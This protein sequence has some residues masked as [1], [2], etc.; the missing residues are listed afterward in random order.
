MSTYSYHIHDSFEWGEILFFGTCTCLLTFLLCFGGTHKSN[1]RRGEN[2]SHSVKKE[3]EKFYKNFPSSWGGGSYE[4]IE[5]SKSNTNSSFTDIN[6]FPSFSSI[7]SESTVRVATPDNNFSDDFNPSFGSGEDHS[8]LRGSINMFKSFGGVLV[9]ALPSI[10]LPFI[11][12]DK[13]KKLVKEVDNFAPPTIDEPTTNDDD[14]FVNVGAKKPVNKSSSS[15]IDSAGIVKTGRLITLGARKRD[16]RSPT[17]RE[18]DFYLSGYYLYYF[19]K[20][21]MKREFQLRDAVITKHVVRAT[22]GVFDG[23]EFYSLGVEQGKQHIM[24]G[25][26]SELYRD[27]WVVALQNHVDLLR[28]EEE[29]NDGEEEE[30]RRRGLPTLT[31]MRVLNPLAVNKAL[32]TLEVFNVRRRFQTQSEE[33]PINNVRGSIKV[34]VNAEHVVNPLHPGVTKVA[35]KSPGKCPA[36]V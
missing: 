26:V 7:S 33:V 15:M 34:R 27:E 25:A 35:A 21:S 36:E 12:K 20:Y 31:E 19:D 32:D 16:E 18:R 2:T 5:E 10:H 8:R 17:V 13:D 11:E 29:A 9:S 22:S 24:L 3:G 30:W 23:Q 4:A 1:R 14:I 28:K 6:G